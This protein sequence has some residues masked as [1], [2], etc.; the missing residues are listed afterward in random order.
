MASKTQNKFRYRRKLFSHVN[1][2]FQ[3]MKI[4][5]FSAH[6]NAWTFCEMICVHC[7]CV[8]VQLFI[9]CH[10]NP[11]VDA[12]Q[13]HRGKTN[14]SRRICLSRSERSEKCA[15]RFGKIVETKQQL[16]MW[17]KTNTRDNVNGCVAIKSNSHSQKL[18]ENTMRQQRRRRHRK[19][20]KEERKKQN[21]W[22][23]RMR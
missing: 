8:C 17:N 16:K 12:K 21:K 6:Q 22:N 3:S 7:W 15:T 13:A 9:G 11:R 19:N 1:W 18:N 20:K 2:Q 23:R 10:D 4:N 14:K 5:C